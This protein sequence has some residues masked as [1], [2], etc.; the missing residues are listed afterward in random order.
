M[1]VY[2]YKALSDGAADAAA[3]EG[4]I[5]ADSPRQARDRLRA[6]GLSVTDLA[7]QRPESRPGRWHDYFTRRQAGKVTG[8]LQEVSTLLNAGIPLLD[9]LDTIARQHTGAFQ[10][11]ILL[12]RDHVAAG[13]S[14][15][16]AMALQPALFDDLCR[17]IVEVGEN[18]GTLERALDRL[19][20][21]RQRSA[22]LKNR[23]ATA[24]TY[25]CILLLVGLG[26]S[27]FLMTYV[28]PNLLD[29]LQR[30][31]KDLPLATVI[32]RNVSDFLV[33]WWWALLLGVGLLAV[34]GAAALRTDRGRMA[35]HR[36][37]LRIPLLG[38]LIRKQAIARLSM[39][40]ATLLKSNV[41]F[42]R[43]IKLAQ[44]TVH[45]RVI[46]GALDTCE[47]AVYSGRDISVALETTNA[48]PPL[49]IQI[50]AVGQA[51]GELE[52]MLENLA[53][54]YDT[55]VNIALNRLTTLLEPIMMILLAI[56]V[57]CIAFATILP[58]L[59]AGD[60]L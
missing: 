28:V 33:G 17:N 6:R 21:F 50:F 22:G 2:A 25:P 30:S 23:V 24:L 7:E 26:V 41:P 55:Q 57:G 53:V 34:G 19:V 12:L 43:A 8:F 49:V 1:A 4:T 37:Q 3:L 20:E 59:E 38:E 15:A 58:I 14:L 13:G 52:Q 40:M 5:S 44:R 39:V 11:S 35:W 31:N 51:S 32:V 42:V 16:E 27:I 45:N 36:L 29:V 48:F 9:A 46:R 18:T 54:N 56:M 10:R 60:V 47:R